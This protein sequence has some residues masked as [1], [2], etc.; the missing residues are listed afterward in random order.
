M[1]TALSEIYDLFMLNVTDYRLTDLYATSIEDFETFMKGWLQYA[2]VDF[3][4]CDQSLDYDDITN[5]FTIT[6]SRENK[7][8]L[9]TL[10]MKYW[11]QKNLND[12]T[13]FNL[14]IVDKEF[15][16]NSESQ[17]MREKSN[18]LNI[19]KEQCS[20][21]LNDYSYRRVDWNSW[22]NQNFAGS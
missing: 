6:L 8:I 21:M 14:H 16:V 10:L 4:M 12:I 22:F 18:Q 7:T 13:Q 20:Q 2:I 11:M 3:Y 17:N 1:A 5:T 15:K 9:A 19:V